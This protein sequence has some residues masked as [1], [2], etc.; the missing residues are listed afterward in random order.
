MTT[1]GPITVGTSSIAFTTTG[2]GQITTGDA[3]S[4]SG[5]TL[6]VNTMARSSKL[7]VQMN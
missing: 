3:L 1:D 7:M 6:N 5:N 4:K 2:T